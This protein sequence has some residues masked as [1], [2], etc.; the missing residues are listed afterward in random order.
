MWFGY[1][2]LCTFSVIDDFSV[3]DLN[4]LRIYSKS[5]CYPYLGYILGYSYDSFFYVFL[6]YYYIY[7]HV[8][9]PNIHFA[10]RD[11]AIGFGSNACIIYII[12]YARVVLYKKCNFRIYHNFSHPF[13]DRRR[14]AYYLS[15]TLL[16][17]VNHRMWTAQQFK[18]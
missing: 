13:T 9:I 12:I 5:L 7:I 16:S 17:S 14:P 15:P 18:I 4:R 2:N 8:F 3:D 6:Y 11:I 1:A 10:E